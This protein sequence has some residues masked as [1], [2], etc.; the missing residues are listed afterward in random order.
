MAGVSRALQSCCSTLNRRLK[1]FGKAEAAELRYR[2]GDLQPPVGQIDPLHGSFSLMKREELIGGRLRRVQ[3]AQVKAL[4]MRPRRLHFQPEARLVIGEGDHPFGRPGQTGRSEVR[5]KLPAGGAHR[6][7]V[8]SSSVTQRHFTTALIFYLGLSCSLLAQPQA[9]GRISFPVSAAG[10]AR[11]HFTRGVLLLHSFEYAEARAEFIAARRLAGN[12]AMAYWGEAMTYNEPV[13]FG[14]DPVS[15]RAALQRLAPTRAERRAKAPTER[16]RAYLNAVE[17]LYGPGT[18]EARDLDYSAAMASLRESYPDDLEAAAFYALSLLGTCHRGR[19]FR[20]Y[21][22]A[23]SI[24]E[25]VFAANPEHP[26]ALHYLIHCYDDPIHAPLGLRA[27][28][29]Y[30][31]IAPASAHARHMPSHIFFGLGMWP[32]GAA[33]N[34]AS[35]RAARDKADRTRQPLEAAGYHALWWLEYAYLQQGR[36][37]EAR[38]AVDTLEKLP[39]AG[40]A[41]LLRFHLVQMRALYSIETGQLYRSGA[42]LSG[43]DLTGAGADLLAAG[44]SAINSGK[45]RDAESVLETLRQLRRRAF[46][47]PSSASGV[48]HQVYPSDA[49]TL[50]II[51]NELAAVLRLAE[52]KSREALELMKA[53]IALEEKLPFEFG[54]PSP[55][56]PAHELMGEMLLQLQQPGL[57]RVQFELSLLRAPRRALSLLGLA[58]SL[59]QS[60][61]KP[62][63]R[64]AYHD[65]QTIWSQ[66][67]PAVR[68]ALDA[69]LR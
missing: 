66:A 69:S 15:A 59:T 39:A 41:P 58:R 48:H 67:D 44:M 42:D 12:F 63:A 46:E 25:D 40:S 7:G 11:E 23:A 51:E 17:I 45:Q 38:R 43:L 65:L 49:E 47:P 27:A 53:A 29:R 22:R 30:A 62:A 9:L 61:Q 50:Q 64:Q 5:Q 37:E 13:W 28:R 54:P 34:D 68:K 14:Q 26:G 1:Q 57:A 32:E 3:P 36:Y 18:K 52:G 20:T 4:N 16:E 33:A 60:G 35:W 31:R 24:A 56:K 10:E 21:M 2:T 6:L 19:D 8:E 55:P